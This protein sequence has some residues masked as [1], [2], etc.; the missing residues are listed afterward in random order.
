MLLLLSPIGNTLTK[1]FFTFPSKFVYRQNHPYEGH[2]PP[3]SHL[4]PQ[5]P[6]FSSSHCHA[7]LSFVCWCLSHLASFSNPKWTLS[8]LSA[9]F[10]R[11]I[12]AHGPTNPLVPTSTNEKY[13][14]QPILHSLM[15]FLKKLMES[16]ASLHCYINIS[17][18]L[19]RYIHCEMSAM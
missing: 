1:T 14:A 4:Q 3:T 5:N 15:P 8:F 7:K 18:K 19:D 6:I 12:E 10:I 2:L 17:I 13:R 9:A 11:L 16:Y